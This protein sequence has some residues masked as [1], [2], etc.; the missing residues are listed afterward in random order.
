MASLPSW[1]GEIVRVK[2]NEPGCVAHC[3]V[4]TFNF[5][6]DGERALAALSGKQI[7]GHEMRM[8]WGKPVPIPLHPVYVPP[9][10]LKYTMPPTPSGLP[11]NCQPETQ[12][13]ERWGGWVGRPQPVPTEERE[14]RK[15][16]RMLARATIKVV[17]PTDRTQL[18]L[19]NRMVEFVI[20]EGPIFEA[21]IMNRELANP[22]FKFLFENQSPEHLYYRWRLFS[23]LQGET[24][25]K[26][27]MEPFRMFKHGSMWKPPLGNVFTGGMPSEIL[28]K[29]GGSLD[30][31]EDSQK[32]EKKKESYKPP[33]PTAAPGKRPLSDKQRDT[34]E[35]SLRIFLMNIALFLI[36][37]K[38]HSIVR[39][40]YSFKEFIHSIV[41]KNIHS[42]NVFI[43]KIIRLFIQ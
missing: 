39:Q 7:E 12:D 31:V 23:M 13:R 27:S 43:Q 18:C 33:P 16:D 35:E 32:G 30:P 8:G 2:K 41:R 22:Q 20:R 36:H 17:I 10:L 4:L 15:F 3:L 6:I 9:A 11:F 21:T 25:D 42:K 29:D 1:P 26:W 5:R 14:R 37:S 34:L 40:K 38:T 19:I 24:K 28:D